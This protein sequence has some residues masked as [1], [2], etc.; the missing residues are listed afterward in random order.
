MTDAEENVTGRSS[1]MRRSDGLT[2][3]VLLRGGRKLMIKKSHAIG[4]GR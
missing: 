3:N 1:T 4:S 2:H